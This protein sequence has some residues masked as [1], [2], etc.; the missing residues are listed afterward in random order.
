VFPVTFKYLNEELANN[1]VLDRLNSVGDNS[2]PNI[3]PLLSGVANE[4]ID[5]LNIA[6]ETEF[7]AKT[8]NQSTYHDMFPFIWTEYEKEG[9]AT[10]Y[11]EDWGWLSTFV[12]MKRGFRFPP[13]HFFYLPFWLK[14]GGMKAA[15]EFCLNDVP[16]YER[17]LNLTRQFVEHMH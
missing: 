16:E 10:L 3:L 17:S 11:N 13:T 7:F 14:Y 15:G 4:R 9:Y 1:V 6:D 12:Y 8:L 5:E 2:Y